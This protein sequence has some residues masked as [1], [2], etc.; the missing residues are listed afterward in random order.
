M[1]K[2]RQSHGAPS[3]ARA[4]RPREGILLPHT[5]EQSQTIV[6]CSVAHAHD[7][8]LQ[9]HPGTTSA[10]RNELLRSSARKKVPISSLGHNTHSFRQPAGTV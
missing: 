7:T 8:G 9:R 10:T 6:L 3:T 1:R 4:I 2:E 5:F